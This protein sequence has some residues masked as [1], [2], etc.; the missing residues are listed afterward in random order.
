MNATFFNHESLM[1]DLSVDVS[2]TIIQSRLQRPTELRYINNKRFVFY[3]A[4]H[5]IIV[6]TEIINKHL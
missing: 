6:L 3:D 1:A 5:F 4:F 2:Q